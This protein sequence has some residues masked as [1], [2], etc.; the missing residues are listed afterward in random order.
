M[1]L[2]VNKCLRLLIGFLLLAAAPL[3]AQKVSPMFYKEVLLSHKPYTL[4]TLTREIQRQSGITFSYD[5]I[6]IDPDRKVKLKRSLDRLTVKELLVLLRKKTGI[7]YKIVGTSHIIYTLPGAGTKAKRNDKHVK[8][9]KYKSKPAR[10]PYSEPAGD[11][12]EPYIAALHEDS[13][14]E[15]QIIVIGDS[16]TAVSY[17]LSGGGGDGGIYPGYNIQ[18]YP[19]DAGSS[20]DELAE[21]A[22]QREARGKSSGGGFYAPLGQS[23]GVL[24]IK[25]NIFAEAG[26]TA[27]ELY[28]LDPTLSMGFSFLY[29]TISYNL[30]T[31]AHWRY[32]LGAAARFNN[33]WSVHF[34]WTTGSKLSQN[35]NIQ[36]FDTIYQPPPIDTLE[37]PEPPTIIENNKPLLVQSTL[38][39]FSVGVTWDMGKHLSLGA[40]VTMNFLNTTYSSNGNKVTLNDFLP[41][42]YDAD[43]KYRTVKPPY[44]I[45][46]SYN[47]N[48]PSNTKV[49]LGLQLRFMY[50]LNFFE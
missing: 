16:A 5:A 10:Q 6:K 31:F 4:H 7:S 26:L 11:V 22:L 46:N 39:R 35:Y 30:G 34:E 33:G 47:G 27:D 36:T 43:Q 19:N 49:W 42:G 45:S 24:F 12:V 15:R 21:I 9:L 32:G 1:A 29:G 25:K 40:A 48:N 44:L 18:N 14:T 8:P 41:I 2:P 17:Y 23:A 20:E 38:N 13:T 3:S 50:R 28:Y 37:P